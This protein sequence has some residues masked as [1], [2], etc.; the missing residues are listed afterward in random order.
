M[1]SWLERAAIPEGSSASTGIFEALRSAIES[2][3][4]EPGTRIPSETALAAHFGVSRPMVREALKSAQALGL[5]RTRLGSGTYVA[6]AEAHPEV[7]YGKY[8]ARDLLEARPAIEI[9]AAGWAARRRTEDQLA[10]LR[11][12]L[13]AMDATEDPERWVELDSRFHTAIAEASGN[14]LFAGVIADAREALARQSTLVNLLAHRR[15]ASGWE[16]RSIFE[17]IATGSAESAE[18]AMRFHLAEVKRVM[19]PIIDAEA[20][21]G[22]D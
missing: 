7:S 5:T 15:G 14:H 22:E 9:P 13:E 18:A 16:H 1:S 21:R 12:L 8:S 2:G 20:P 4:L 19:T 17:A 10:G 11:D 6:S 3:E